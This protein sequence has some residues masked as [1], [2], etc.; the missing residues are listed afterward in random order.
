M[1]EDPLLVGE[2][3]NFPA[4]AQQK[5]QM[6]GGFEAFLLGSLRF[7]KIGRRIG[8]AKSAVNLQQAEQAASLDDLDFITDTDNNSPSVAYD[9]TFLSYLKE[10][11]SAQTDMYP[12]LPNPYVYDL[13]PSPNTDLEGSSKTDVLPS[14]SK[15]VD[16]GPPAPFTL[17]I[18]NDE[19]TVGH[20][21]DTLEPTTGRITTEK[22]KPA[23]IQVGA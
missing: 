11:S 3:K 10:H 13:Y 16:S 6:A 14:E 17:A 20:H 18:C 21:G 9:N 22:E 4:K 1:A 15:I 7:I 5:I 2:L 23:P 8:L 19:P 12:I